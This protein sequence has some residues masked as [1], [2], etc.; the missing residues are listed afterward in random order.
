MAS[1]SSP[2]PE[3]LLSSF[4]L[5]I[6]TSTLFFMRVWGVYGWHRPPRLFSYILLS[7]PTSRYKQHQLLSHK[8]WTNKMIILRS[9]LSLPL[10][11]GQYS[12]SSITKFSE[13]W[14]PKSFK[15]LRHEMTLLRDFS[16][17][18]DNYVDDYDEEFSCILSSASLNV[19][20]VASLR[21]VSF[22][23]K[24]R[25]ECNRVCSNKHCIIGRKELNFVVLLRNIVDDLVFYEGIWNP[26]KAELFLR[27]CSFGAPVY[28]IPGFNTFHSERNEGHYPFDDLTDRGRLWLIALTT[29]NRKI[30]HEST[31]LQ[32]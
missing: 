6:L 1:F 9:Y 11:H 14:V 2:A 18:Y 8:A 7:G 21:K 22:N 27:R 29:S 4:S 13:K 12:L 3:M 28:E 10:S 32:F 31:N 30:K 20:D 23:F 17:L 26:L 25:P 19:K 5:L 24:P 16:I 15:V